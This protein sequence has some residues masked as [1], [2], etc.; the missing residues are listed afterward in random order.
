MPTR[1]TQSPRELGAG[2]CTPT[3][4]ATQSQSAND[5]PI[6]VRSLDVRDGG[7]YRAGRS[8]DAAFYMTVGGLVAVLV[9][10]GLRENEGIF[11]TTCGLI[12]LLFAGRGLVTRRPR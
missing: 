4:K 12:A 7:S 5:A 2:Q 11:R 9:L 10:S 3:T 6:S 8:V 1:T